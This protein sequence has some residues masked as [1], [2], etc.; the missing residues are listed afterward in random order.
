MNTYVIVGCGGTGYYL[1]EPLIKYLA[2]R[3][4]S[5]QL[6][7][8]D[9]DEVED[10]NLTRAFNQDAV[11]MNKAEALAERFSVSNVSVEP[12]PYFVKPGKTWRTVH[13]E[14]WFSDNVTIFGA[15]DNLPT[16]L[17]L[18]EEASKLD[19]VTY[20]D[21]G[22]GSPYDGQV[23][24]YVRRLGKQLSPPMQH[25][26]PAIVNAAEG[27][28]FPGDE[29]CAARSERLPQIGLVNFQLAAAMTWLW[30][31]QVDIPEQSGE[32]LEGEFKNLL[33]MCTLDCSMVAGSNL[34]LVATR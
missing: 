34:G 6:Y 28:F 3:H 13:S 29:N 16:R 32:L 22:N 31:S 23:I 2:N 11:G 7:L 27:D 33:D 12:V 8:V 4:E 5:S 30:M 9:G 10:S 19:N 25:I 18:Q 26:F 15:V 14:L 20:V 24:L 17:F 1:I 21:G